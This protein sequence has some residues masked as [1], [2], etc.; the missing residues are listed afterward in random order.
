MQRAQHTKLEARLHAKVRL[1]RVGVDHAARLAYAQVHVFASLVGQALDER[2]PQAH[3]LDAGAHQCAQQRQCR[4]LHVAALGLQ[5]AHVV[6]AGELLQ[7]RIGGAG[8]Q[9]QRAGHVGQAHGLG[10]L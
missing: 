6:V 10:L 5:A 1:H 8:R 4:A 7:Q 3:D 2:M 9:L